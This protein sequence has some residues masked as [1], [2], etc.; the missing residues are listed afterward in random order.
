ML[1][2]PGWGL[3]VDLRQPVLITVWKLLKNMV[4]LK[5]FG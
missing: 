2:R 1:Y 4:Y 3:S 5:D